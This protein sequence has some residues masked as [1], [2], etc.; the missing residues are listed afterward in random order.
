MQHPP[1]PNAL[2]LEPATLSG[3][4]T[5]ILAPNMLSSFPPASPGTGQVPGAWPGSGP[6]PGP[7]AVSEASVRARAHAAVKQAVLQAVSQ[8]GN[9]LLPVESDG[10]RGMLYLNV[11]LYQQHIAGTFSGLSYLALQIE[12][13]AAKQVVRRRSLA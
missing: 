13:D 3:L 10:E 8:G 1:R 6:D 9:V 2:E 4:H 7:G 12:L 5:L 11:V